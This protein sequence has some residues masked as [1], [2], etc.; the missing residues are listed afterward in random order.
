LRAAATPD[1]IGEASLAEAVSRIRVDPE[2]AV[3]A[4]RDDELP[5][6]NRLFAVAPA[7]ETRAGRF[8]VFRAGALR[9][10]LD[11]S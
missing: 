10:S 4:V 6:F 8:S 2:D 7:P 3:I 11:G 1:R 9:R 5:R